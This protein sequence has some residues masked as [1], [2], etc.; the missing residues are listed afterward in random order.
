[1]AAHTS[2]A[3]AGPIILDRERASGH[4]RHRPGAGLDLGDDA[5]GHVRPDDVVAAVLLVADAV[6]RLDVDGVGDAD[7][8]LQFKRR[9]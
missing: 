8:R 4:G 5:G 7:G 3:L 9:R 1:M 6:Q 2:S